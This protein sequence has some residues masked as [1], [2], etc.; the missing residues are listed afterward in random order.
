MTAWQSLTLGDIVSSSWTP[1]AAASESPGAGG[2]GTRRLDSCAGQGFVLE[3][4]GGSL[5]VSR[6]ASLVTHTSKHVQ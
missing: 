4:A 6:G 3:T 2:R 5:A 1:A